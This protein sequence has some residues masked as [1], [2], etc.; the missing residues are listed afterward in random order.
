[1]ETA[2]DEVK[3][4]GI[5][6][7]ASLTA[8]GVEFAIIGGQAIAA[9]VA[10]VDVEAVR[11]TKDVDL[12]VKRDDLPKVIQ[13]LEAAGFVHG[14]DLFLDGPDGSV[15]SGLHL[16][17]AGEKVREEH[18]TDAPSLDHVVEAGDF[19]VLDLDG[20]VRMKLAA[21]RLK[22]QVHLL[23]LIE[24]GLIDDGWVDRVP[25]VLRE[26]MRAVLQTAVDES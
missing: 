1:M 20:L 24:V 2:V 11:N 23:D 9:W 22:D 21:F 18:P 15:R 4:R 13:T 10:Q 17:F 25:A 3:T 26:R 19:P 16:V 5:R 6:A 12:L 14:V 8:A 7:A